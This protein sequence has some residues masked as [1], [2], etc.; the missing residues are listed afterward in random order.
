L[1]CAV[2]EVLT[3]QVEVELLQLEC[4][5]GYRQG[6]AL[7]DDLDGGAQVLKLGAVRHVVDGQLDIGALGEG[8]DVADHVDGRLAVAGCADRIGRDIDRCPVERSLTP[9]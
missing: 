8:E 5:A 1:A 6:A 3:G 9:C 7:G 2:V 4:L